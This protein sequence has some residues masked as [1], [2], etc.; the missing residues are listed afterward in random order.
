MIPPT[1]DPP[2][3]SVTLTCKDASNI[4]LN[5]FED[6][7]S[8]ATIRGD[9][10]VFNL[11]EIALDYVSDRPVYSL[12]FENA[13]DS[14]Y[15][16]LILEED[17][18]C[19]ISSNRKSYLLNELEY[20]Q[21][22][23]ICLGSLNSTSVPPKNCGSVSV[24][25]AYREQEWLLNKD[26][27]LIIGLGC[28]C[29][30]IISLI[31]GFLVFYVI[32]KYPTLIKSSK[33]VV[34]VK[35]KKP[36]VDVLIMPNYNSSRAPTAEIPPPSPSVVSSRSD[37]YMTPQ[38]AFKLPENHGGLYDSA[39]SYCY[40]KP[41]ATCRFHQTQG[42]RPTVTNSLY[43]NYKSENSDAPPLPP[44]HPKRKF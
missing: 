33:R 9:H 26:K 3:Y 32:R 40:C 17:Y 30:V 4:F 6:H 34:V 39:P 16:L 12:N 37:G 21:V 31:S 44:N 29:M 8:T 13:L 23:T 7:N 41:L 15:L 28:A 24:P 19:R 38:A 36:S 18:S 1:S 22:Y 5:P 10:L 25:R 43:C 27:S 20:G 42:S 11:T 2:G 14:D 35:K